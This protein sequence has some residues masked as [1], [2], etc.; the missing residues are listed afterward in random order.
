MG[1]KQFL[2]LKDKEVD[3]VMP[4]TPDLIKSN[5]VVKSLSMENASL[6]GQIARIYAEKKE[7]EPE[8]EDP[9]V[10]DYI[11]NINEQYDEII[12]NRFG[13]TFSHRK[14]WAAIFGVDPDD[15]SDFGKEI[16]VTDKDDEIIFGKFKD[17]I[18]LQGSRI[19]ITTSDNRLLVHGPTFS[20]IIWKPDS[21]NNQLKRK[22]IALAIDKDG[23]FTPDIESEEM[24]DIIF[25]NNENVWKETLELREQFKDHLKRR[26]IKIQELMREL[27]RVEGLFIKS[28]ME[29][30]D[31]NRIISMISIQNETE[32]TKVSSIM[33]EYNQQ[34]KIFFDMQ[35]EINLYSEYKV[36]KEKETQIK[37]KVIDEL[38]EKLEDEQSQTKY[39]R[40]LDELRD[41]GMYWNEMLREKAIIPV[42]A[43]A[44]LTSPNTP[45]GANPGGQMRQ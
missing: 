27:Q 29:I 28:K 32:K 8:D 9:K 30:D 45:V 17:F 36:F 25:D 18:N 44:R 33:H 1:I 41:S 22:R 7:T 31:K 6:K 16:D 13:K 12:K 24:P 43:P 40:V 38:L 11:K 3:V 19:G 35:K 5:E 39:E 34:N 10:Q 37:D 2:G 26:D 21:L 42:E 4:V 23:N 20:S 15:V 14:F